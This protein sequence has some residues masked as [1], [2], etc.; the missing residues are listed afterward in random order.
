MTEAT[1]SLKLEAVEREKLPG[2]APQR[3]VDESVRA[4]VTHKDRP[5]HE[6]E[7]KHLLK[8]S[9]L[10]PSARRDWL[11]PPGPACHLTS[12]PAFRFSR[13]S[14]VRSVRAMESTGSLL[15]PRS[16]PQHDSPSFPTSLE[17]RLLSPDFTSSQPQSSLA[18]DSPHA[19]TGPAT[20]ER[21]DSEEVVTYISESMV[22]TS[23]DEEKLL[24]LNKNT[25]LRRLN[26]ELVKLNQEWDHI[27]RSTTLEM[28]QKLGS[29][30][31]EV[32]SLKQKTERLTMKLEHEQNKREYYEQTL[33]QELKKNQHLQE[34][35]RHLESK[36]PLSGN[37]KPPL[38]L[39]VPFSATWEDYGDPPFPL[40]RKSLKDNAPRKY[41]A[42]GQKG[43][44]GEPPK[45]PRHKLLSSPGR[46]LLD[47]SDP[48]KE[49]TDLKDQLE[50]LRCQTEIY[51]A[52]YL[53]EHKDRERI[54][55]ENVK[56]RK[57]EEE[58][59]QQMMLLQEQLKIFEDDF[60][61]E[62][63]DKQV[64]QRLLKSKSE[65][66]KPVLVH[67]CN[68]HE[69]SP[70]P[71]PASSPQPKQ[72]GGGGGGK[73]CDRPSPKHGDCPRHCRRRE[74]QAQASPFTRD[75]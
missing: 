29:L 51:E 49:V 30:Q 22:V 21:T 39:G 40:A 5:G 6:E 31:A 45:T 53:T 35:V 38:T 4:Q 54:K 67:R 12:R 57:K 43:R 60:R 23:A 66:Q 34:Y 59:R 44:N 33:V 72:G 28:Q 13:S 50:V 37:A 2:S 17:R 55:A 75:Y 61:K 42:A 9:S 62:R 36:M 3:G 7:E 47:G 19:P 48:K 58:M 27:Y 64:L 63:S 11:R 65:A 26:K 70:G 20:E 1:S 15:A 68:G 32:V 10:L 73:R 41:E 56:L 46:A 14:P 74:A 69:K 18:L 71:S 16:P 52:D 8:L 25:E 24:L